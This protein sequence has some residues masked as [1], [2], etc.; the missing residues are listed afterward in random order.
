[1]PSRQK[2]KR[3]LRNR[4]RRKAVFHVLLTLRVRGSDPHAEREEYSHSRP[5]L[6]LPEVPTMSVTRLLALGALGCWLLLPAPSHGQD[7]TSTPTADDE[8]LLQ[9]HKIPTDAEG[10]LQFFRQQTL[11]GEDQQTIKA[12]VADLA[13]P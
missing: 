3:P 10:L 1:M 13:S 7:K 12:L 4:L 6:P 11:T 9:T 8:K 2:A 5:R